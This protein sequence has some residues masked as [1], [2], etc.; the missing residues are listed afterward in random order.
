[1][2]R[3]GLSGPLRIWALLGARAGDN[4][5]VLALC[6]AIGLPFEIK[7]LE[8]NGLR[9]LGPRLLGR[10]L[11]SLR[12]PS[13]ELA[14]SEPPPDLTISAGHR[15]VPLV[16]AL[17]QRSNSRTR[18]IHIGFPRVSPS[19]FDLVIATPQYPI[20]DHPNLLRVP[21]ALT[22]AATAVPDP[23]DEARLATFPSPKR[24][25]LVGGPNIYWKI[26][27]PKLLHA[28]AALLQEASEAGGSV[29][30]TTSPRTPPELKHAIEAALARSNVPSLLA[31]PGLPPSYSSLLAAADSIHVTADSV[32]MVSDAIWTGKPVAT[33]PVATSLLGRLA[34]AICG[35][36]GRRLY[37]QDLR[38]FWTA[39]DS[40]GISAQLALPQTSTEQVLHT[41]MER[42]R[43]ILDA[44]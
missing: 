2:T 5:Q 7:Q 28:L 6:E 44:N 32:A 9:R 35:S 24:L 26:D 36:A 16:R 18:S 12:G 17:R 20:P 3:E 38:H 1:L 43:P 11:A 29:L 34:I 14:L 23:A 25:L 27:D 13:R 39:L 22:R 15:S 31:A 40:I 21:F 4:N 30:V 8:Y 37:P 42:I 33:V 41:I 19:H 10:S